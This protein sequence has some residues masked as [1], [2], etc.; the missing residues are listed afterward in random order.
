MRRPLAGD[1]GLLGGHR[2]GRLR[3]IRPDVLREVLKIAALS[4]PLT[5]ARRGPRCRTGPPAIGPPTGSPGTD[6]V[7]ILLF[8]QPFPQRHDLSSVI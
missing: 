3:D 6:R 1:L 7:R 2:R 8:A 5:V 4:A